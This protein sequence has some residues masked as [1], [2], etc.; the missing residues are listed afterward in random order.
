MDRGR[1]GD[2]DR[3]IANIERMVKALYDY[4]GHGGGGHA[5][6]AGGGGGDTAGADSGTDDEKGRDGR[7]DT[8]AP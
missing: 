2:M 5:G 1:D 8:N 3:R 4:F 6:R 7:S